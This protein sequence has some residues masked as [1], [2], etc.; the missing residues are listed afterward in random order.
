MQH[1]TMTSAQ[2]AQFKASKCCPQCLFE[3]LKRGVNLKQGWWLCM[4]CETWWQAPAP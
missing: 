3:P 4:A 2:E 1:A